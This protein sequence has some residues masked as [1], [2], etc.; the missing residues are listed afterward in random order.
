MTFPGMDAE[1]ARIAGRCIR[2]AGGW[3]RN[4]Q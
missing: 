1:C 3:T 4:E 2:M